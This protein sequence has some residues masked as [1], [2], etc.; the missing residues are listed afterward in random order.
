MMT[1]RQLLFESYLGLGGI[2][3]ADLADPLAPK[4]RHHPS[5]AKGSIF[6]FME[7]GG[8]QLA[9]CECR[10]ALLKCAGKRMRR[11]QRAEGETATFPAAPNRIIPPQWGF[12]QHGRSGRWMSDLLPELAGC[13]DD[14]AFLHGV[15]VDNNNH[16]PAV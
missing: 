13:V 10:P 9:P 8:A 2:A 15:K 16:G 1:R 4:R 6:L 3:L 12:T 7:A 11:V 5:K 14:L